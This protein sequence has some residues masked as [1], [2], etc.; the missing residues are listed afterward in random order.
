[1]PLAGSTSIIPLILQTDAGAA[2]TYADKAAFTTAGWDVVFYDADGDVLTVDWDLNPDTTATAGDTYLLSFTVPFGYYM[3]VVEIVSTNLAIPAAFSDF[4]DTATLGQIK[5]AIAIAGGVFVTDTVSNS[6]I[7]VFQGDSISVDM[8]IPE[9]ALTAVD[10]VSVADLSSYA[11]ELKLEATDAT[12]APVA[13]DFTETVVSD[14]SGERIVRASLNAFPSALDV[15]GPNGT[16]VSARIDLRI[17]KG[18]KTRVAATVDL[19]VVWT[20][21][22][23]G[24]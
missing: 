20:A 3:A 14:T 4:G 22:A 2:L 8:L 24:A 1:M 23:G 6:A 19:T 13:V 15:D 9:A 16:S 18:S 11:A 12:A 17:T 7:T 5:S 10:A 21:N